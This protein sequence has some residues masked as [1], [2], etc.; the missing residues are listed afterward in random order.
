M[1][2]RTKQIILLGLLLVTSIL[3]WF[4]VSKLLPQLRWDSTILLWSTVVVAAVLAIL[5]AL[6]VILVEN[7]MLLILAAAGMSFFSIVFF[8]DPIFMIA[9]GVLF[10]SCVVGYYRTYFSVQNTLD[11]SLAR[12]L[13]KSVPL[14]VTCL[15]AVFSTAFYIKNTSVEIQLESIIPEKYFIKA[16][17]YA[18]PTI[19]KIDPS[20]IPTM[21][22]SDAIIFQ[23][24]K[25]YPTLTKEQATLTVDENLKKYSDQLEIRVKPT[26]SYVHVLYL[27]GMSIIRAQTDAYK[28]AFPKIYAVA[29]FFTLRILAFPVYWLAIGIAIMLLRTLHRFGIVELRAVPATILA[30][31]FSP[32]KTQQ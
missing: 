22:I 13:R 23:V 5:W 21:T 12:P 11:G 10:V 14:L 9:T 30:Y 32:P 19:K 3:F 6:T 26:D 27:T 24:M 31:S 17:E 15:I 8:P 28:G 18:A 16:A 7:T 2:E 25:D 20:F 4:L 29:L 1:T